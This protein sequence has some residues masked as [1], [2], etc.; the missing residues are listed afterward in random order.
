MNTQKIA[1]VFTIGAL[2]IGLVTACG[3]SEAEETTPVTT[4]Q[5]VYRTATETVTDTTTTTVTTTVDGQTPVAATPNG[6]EYAEPEE[7][8]AVPQRAYTPPEPADTG[9]SAYYANCTAARAAGAA[10]VYRGQP[11]YAS[12]LDRDNDGVGCE[13]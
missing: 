5:T 8:D 12:H 4:T 3:T 7:V 11:G 2:T 13:N 6:P 10:P 9:A 1:S